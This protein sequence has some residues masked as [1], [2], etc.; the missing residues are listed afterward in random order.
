MAE[1]LAVVGSVVLASLAIGAGYLLW[2]LAGRADAALT[3]ELRRMHDT[4]R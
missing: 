4:D 2:R 1:A 3:A